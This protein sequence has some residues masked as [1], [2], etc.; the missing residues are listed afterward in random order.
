MRVEQAPNGARGVDTILPFT[1]SRAKAIKG[2]GYDYVVRYLGVLT[3]P[4]RN[5]ILQAGLALLAVNYSR[6]PGWHPSASIGDLDGLASVAHARKA[7]LPDG[8][9]L[10]CDIEGPGG[11]ANDTIAHVNAWATRVQAAGYK[12]GMYVGYGIQ[13]SDVQMY[14]DLKVTGYWDSCS[15]NVDVAKRGFQMFQHYPPNVHVAGLQVDVNHIE[16]DGMGD[17]PSWLVGDP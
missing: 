15:R 12:A 8:M 9:S 14:H 3:T 4:E 16:T 5:I 7:G 17:T 2:A 10:Y 13:L 11:G 6:R 1:A